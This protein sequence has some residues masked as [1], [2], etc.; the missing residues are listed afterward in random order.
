MG[1]YSASCVAGAS[2]TGL[3]RGNASV[4][5]GGAIAHGLGSTPSMAIVT[6]EGT[7]LYNVSVVRGAT[8]LTI[9]HDAPGS[10]T[11][12]WLAML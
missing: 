8:N 6:V 7:S 1:I 2:I 10:I 5:S 11:V 9:Y 12:S 3:A 4:A